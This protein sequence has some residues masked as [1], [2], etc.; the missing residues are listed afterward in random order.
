MLDALEWEW[1]NP[2]GRRQSEVERGDGRLLVVNVTIDRSYKSRI[3]ERYSLAPPTL[4]S[5]TSVTHFMFGRTPLNFRRRRFRVT[6]PTS[7]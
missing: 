1:E 7:P 5:V 2:R 4:N 6:F 3:G